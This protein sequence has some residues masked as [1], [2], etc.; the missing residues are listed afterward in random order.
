MKNVFKLVLLFSIF[1]FSFGAHAGIFAATDSYT[2]AGANGQT[3]S[4]PEPACKAVRAITQPTWV[5]VSTSSVTIYQSNA[6][7]MMTYFI[8][9]SS[10]YNTSTIFG[11]VRNYTCPANSTSMGY[12]SAYGHHM[13]RDNCSN[14]QVF[15]TATNTC[16]N[17]SSQGFVN[18]STDKNPPNG[19]PSIRNPIQ[20]NT[21]N[22]TQSE[23]DYVSATTYPLNF[24]RYYNLYQR[25]GLVLGANWLGTPQPRILSTPSLTQVIVLRPS[26]LKLPFN[27]ST[28][29]WFTSVDVKDV[30]IEL[31]DTNFVRTGW[32][33]KEDATGDIET[34]DANGKLLSVADR[35][36]FTKTFSYS[37]A[38]TPS[39]IAPVP[40][41]LITV[42]DALGRSLNFS[43]D[44][45]SRLK[46]MTNPAGGSYTYSYTTDGNNNLLSVTYPDNKVRTYHYENTTFLNALTGITDEN[47]N[48]FATWGYNTIGKANSSE[49]AGAVEKSTL[50]YNI[51]ASGNPTNTVVT[52]P[53]TGA[54][55][56]YNFSTVL[57]VV[58]NTGQSQPAGSGCAAASSALTYDANGNV[59][60]RKDFNGNKTTYVYDMARNLETSRTEGLTSSGATT[61]ATR[62]ITTTW[63]AT[64]RLPLVISEYTGPTATGTPLKKTTYVYDTK[65]NVTSYKEE[66]PV[67]SLSRIT[68]TTYTYSA[69]V[70]G[71]VLTKAVD[72]PRTDVT[73]TT[74]YVYYLHNATCTPSSAAPIIDPITGVSPPNLGCRGQLQSITSALGQTATYN[75]YNHHGQVEQMT[76]ANG[77]VTTNTYDLRQRLLT[78]AISGTGITTE[79]TT[80]T[81]D[82]VGQVTQLKL[83]DNSTLNYTYDAAHRLTDIQDTL[84]N[85]IHYILDSEGNRVQEDTKDP[86]GGLVKTL[87]RSYDVLNR[88]QQLTGVEQ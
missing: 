85:K 86:N 50:V 35:S 33:Y 60:S 5:Y 7:C 75:R 82:N 29:Q 49:H 34:Y 52:D 69:F 59:S 63:H 83:P 36:G 71:L 68:T 11:V 45:S 8:P 74:T 4:I 23:L 31:R 88:L 46:T 20:P 41:L 10:T 26:G 64:W 16:T 54:V 22:K 61:S 44:S 58:K 21:G 39:N 2:W 38:S 19:C 78:R 47:S 32:T 15:D 1:T 12:L 80:L 72:G 3:T 51:D 81:Y 65:G 28:G 84:G 48:R 77:L 24:I 57:G 14:F 37:T 66:D 30:L 27:A 25:G 70:P 55:R 17:P 40:G 87:T 76:D 9:Q 13:C 73:D 6:N 62:T 79:T 56:T 43:Y 18:P 67:R 42:T 53:G